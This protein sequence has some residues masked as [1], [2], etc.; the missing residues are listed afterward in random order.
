MAS[1]KTHETPVL[2][3]GGG[4]AG[5]I[6]A[7]QLARKGTKCMIAERNLDT[8]RWPKM[9]ITNCRTMELL[10]RLGLDEGVREQG[11][12]QHYSFDVLFSTGLGS[13]GELI[14]KWDLPSPNQWRE[15]IK[16]QNDG[17]MP[18]QPYQRCSQAIFEAWLKP[19]LQKEPLV[20]SHFGLKF[21]SLEETADY[22]VSRL[23]DVTT[24]QLHIVKS[25]YLIGCDGA[26]SRVRRSIGVELVGGPV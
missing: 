2:I 17:S 25:K 20:E 7:I 12:P 16:T 21:E 26:G 23:V 13:E 9:D 22:V 8:T 18:Q 14:S 1:E 24:G 10:R 11:V 5:L 19:I 3:A 6:A 4:P 15:R